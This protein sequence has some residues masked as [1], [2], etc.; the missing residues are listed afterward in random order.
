MLVARV[1]ILDENDVYTSSAPTASRPSHL[2][3]LRFHVRTT[4]DAESRPQLSDGIIRLKRSVDGP[5]VPETVKGKGD[6]VD[7]C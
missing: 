4:Q 7:I 1:A 3:G 2:S 6:V 5:L